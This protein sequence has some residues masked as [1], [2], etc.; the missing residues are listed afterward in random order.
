MLRTV[1][2]FTVLPSPPIPEEAQRLLE[3]LPEW[4]G[5]PESNR[6]Y[7]EDACRMSTLVALSNAGDTV[8]ILLYRSHFARSAE[9]HLMAVHPT[10]HRRGVGQGLV[11]AAES[12]LR[13]DAVEMVS[14]KTLGPSF[15]DVH[16]DATRAFYVACGFVPIEEMH[17]RDWDTPALILAKSLG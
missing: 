11:T 15:P 9:I 17:L 6:E 3:L 1:T 7:V 4:F 5:Q 14:V 8:G 16:Y 10:W 2:T 12:V 13:K